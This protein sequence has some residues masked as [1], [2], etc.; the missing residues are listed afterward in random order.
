[1]EMLCF[2]VIFNLNCLVVELWEKLLHTRLCETIA[3]LFTSLDYA[4]KNLMIYC[5]I[6][7]SVLYI[8]ILALFHCVNQI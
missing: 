4:A 7:K 1:M 8:L 2:C 6:N 3:A 5:H